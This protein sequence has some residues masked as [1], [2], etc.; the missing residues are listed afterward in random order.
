MLDFLMFD[1]EV[2]SIFNTKKQRFNYD[3]SYSS[4]DK[5]SKDVFDFASWC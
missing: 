1:S 2:L 4:L 3:Y 5:E